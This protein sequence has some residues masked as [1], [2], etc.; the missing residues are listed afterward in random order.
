MILDYKYIEQLLEEYFNGETTVEEEKILRTFFCQEN[1]PAHLV[2][3]RDLFVYEQNE[4]KADCLGTDFDAKMMK[5]LEAQE[6][7]TGTK[8][9][10]LPKTSQLAYTVLKSLQPFFRAAAIVA[11]VIT[12]GNASQVLF[13]DS[14][15]EQT[16][17]AT[18]EPTTGKNV[19][20]VQALKQDTMIVD[21]LKA[22]ND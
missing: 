11:V 18:T 16:S 1:I 4:P 13:Q 19:A 15:K 10:E 17:V 8:V 21:T 20:D 6:T 2:Q 5:M 22:I 14:S 7:E 9:V 12:I 3:Y